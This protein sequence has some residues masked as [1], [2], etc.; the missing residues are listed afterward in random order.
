MAFREV[1]M[2]MIRA[3]Q[4]AVISAPPATVYSILA[5]YEVGHPQILPQRYFP[6]L[7]VVQG[8]YGTGTIIRFEMQVLGVR[9][10]LHAEITEPVPGELLLESIRETG[11]LTSFQVSPH[12]DGRSSRVTIKTEL[13]V[14]G[15][16]GWLQ[17]LLIP[18]LL[19]KIYTEELGCL[20]EVLA[21]GAGES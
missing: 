10:T 16:A 12:D 3:E 19:R 4:S 20:S 9:Q 13:Q 6:S 18:R 1:L 5:D 11:A 7:A 8:G 15:F 17:S 14:P 21:K 2:V